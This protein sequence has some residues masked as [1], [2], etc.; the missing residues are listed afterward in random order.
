MI[1]SFWRCRHRGGGKK[2]FDH[3][4]DNRARL[5]EVEGHDG[6]IHS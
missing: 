5:G 2:G 6:R 3:V 4:G 1:G